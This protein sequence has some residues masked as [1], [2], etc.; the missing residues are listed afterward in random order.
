MEETERLANKLQIMGGFADF[1]KER[2]RKWQSKGNSLNL[3]G[4]MC[5]GKNTDIVAQRTR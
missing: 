3:G 4:S 2:C 1:G 5:N